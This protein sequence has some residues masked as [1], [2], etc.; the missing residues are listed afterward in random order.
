MCA[1][2]EVNYCLEDIERFKANVKKDTK[3]L[4]E[5]AETTDDLVYRNYLFHVAEKYD[6]Y[7]HVKQSN[8]KFRSRYFNLT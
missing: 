3:L 4:S 7:I 8:S 2:N 1:R 6:N 5:L